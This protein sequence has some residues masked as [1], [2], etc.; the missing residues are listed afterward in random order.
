MT[1]QHEPVNPRKQQTQGTD[2]TDEQELQSRREFLI[3]LGRWSH[4]VIAGAVV[5]GGVALVDKP[6][7]AG[8]WANRRGGG[9]AWAN[10]GRPAGGGAWVN[11]KGG[12]GAGWANRRGGSGGSW[13]NKR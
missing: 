8:A 6:A 9:G 11:A 2:A 12:G 3:G 5:A 7:Q 1:D 10:G 13:A 4:A